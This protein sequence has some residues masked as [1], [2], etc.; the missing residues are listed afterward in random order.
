MRSRSFLSDT[1]SLYDY[2]FLRVDCIIP[3]LIT[4]AGGIIGTAL[5]GMFSSSNTDKA[6]QAQKD[7]SD[8]TNAT[9]LEIAN[10]NLA[11]QRENL[12]YQKALQQQIFEREDTAY[13]RTVNDMRSAGLSPLSMQ[14]TNGSG[15][16]IQTQ[17]LNNSFQKQGYDVLRQSAFEDLGNSLLNTASSISQID[18]LRAQ[19]K[20]TE[21]EADNI[22]IQNDYS[23]LL[24]EEQLKKARQDYLSGNV[25]LQ[26]AYLDFYNKG[27]K[28]DYDTH[29]GLV[30]NMSDA[31]RSAHILA[32]SLGFVDIPEKL[33]G[34]SYLLNDN[35]TLRW[36]SLSDKALDTFGMFSTGVK[37]LT[38]LSNFLPASDIFTLARSL[39]RSKTKSYK[40]NNRSSNDLYQKSLDNFLPF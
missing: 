36:N 10:Q 40:S 6:N 30:D 26:S 8:E 31:E 20:K 2:D 34:D 25:G 23:A 15:E 19:A 4:A 1:V 39:G 9:N 32:R 13:Q 38:G 29:F 28:T 17:A 3:S 22:K 27:R 33:G 11:F 16:A 12:D 21:A 24:L 18:S 35:G 7:I 5:G 37:A 14:N